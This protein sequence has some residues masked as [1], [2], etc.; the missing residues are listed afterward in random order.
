MRNDAL[1]HSLTHSLAILFILHFSTFFKSSLD[2]EPGTKNFISDALVDLVIHDDDDDGLTVCLLPR[3][4]SLTRN[5]A[6]LNFYPFSSTRLDDCFLRL[7]T[8]THIQS[9]GFWGNTEQ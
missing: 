9:W 6:H 5:R 4:R 2:R 8:L 7:D 1:T 3:G